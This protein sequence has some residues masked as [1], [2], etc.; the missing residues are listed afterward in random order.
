MGH[1][2]SSRSG[3]HGQNVRRVRHRQILTPTR[4]APQ[5]QLRHWQLGH[6]PD[7]QKH[8]KE[9]RH[10]DQGLLERV[11][12]VDVVLLEQILHLD[13]EG[14]HGGGVVVRFGL[15][16]GC[17]EGGEFRLDTGHG[18]CCSDGA[19]KGGEEGDS[20]GEGEGKDGGPPA[21]CKWIRKEQERKKEA[22][23]SKKKKIQEKNN[24]RVIRQD[25]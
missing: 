25:H 18:A 12:R 13:R 1:Q 20:E 11:E 15:G 19:E 8:T 16:H 7:P 6:P 17:L 3:R 23:K 9:N 24:I 22:G 14:L 5:F 21:K 4:D 2:P 10:G